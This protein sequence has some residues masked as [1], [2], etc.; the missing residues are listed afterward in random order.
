MQWLRLAQLFFR[1]TLNV[2]EKANKA[3]DVEVNEADKAIKTAQERWDN[4]LL[5]REQSSHM[6]AKVKE[7]LGE[8]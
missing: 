1:A 6:R 3:L 5:A 8:D 4:A 7:I 2:L